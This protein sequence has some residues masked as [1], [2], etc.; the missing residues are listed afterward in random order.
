MFK[1]VRHALHYAFLIHGSEI[2]KV[3]TTIAELISAGVAV[4]SEFGDLSPHDHHA[5]AAMILRHVDSLPAAQRLVIEGYFDRAMRWPAI[6][7]LTDEVGYDKI[8]RQPTRELIAGYFGEERNDFGERIS[9]RDL[10]RRYGGDHLMYWRQGKVICRK[11]N[12]FHIQAEDAL[13]WKMLDKIER[14]A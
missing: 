8:G 7:V 11:L 13:H 12:V 4:P 9:T 10:A 5:E 14:A 3:S 1:S 2:V 6:Q